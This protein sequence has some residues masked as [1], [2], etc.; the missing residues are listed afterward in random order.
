MEM[1]TLGHSRSSSAGKNRVCVEAAV[2]RRSAPVDRL[3]G[4][5]VV[6]LYHDADGSAC[7]LLADLSSK[8]AKSVAH[9]DI[10]RGAFLRAARTKLSPSLIIAALNRLHFISTNDLSETFATVFV[11]RFSRAKR[12]LRYASGGHDTALIFQ[13]RTHRH[14][15]QTGPIIGVIPHAEY[16]DRLVDFDLGDILLIAT[17][18]FTECRRYRKPSEQLGTSGIV[19]ALQTKIEYSPDSVCSTIGAF[20]DEFTGGEYR[21]DATLV[22]ISRR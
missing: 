7:L 15:T 8:G 17:D 18:G 14:L 16:R 11:A 13:G 21:D 12:T 22:A 3:R 20:A 6:S 10:L 4:G 9:V 1:Q 2:E 19:R 5:D